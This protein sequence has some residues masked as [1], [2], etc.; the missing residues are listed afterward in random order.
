MN[1]VRQHYQNENDRV[2]YN[3]FTAKELASIIFKNIEKACQPEIATE[4][5]DSLQ[6]LLRT[7][8]PKHA[9]AYAARLNQLLSMLKEKLSP[10][11]EH[12]PTLGVVNNHSKIDASKFPGLSLNTNFEQNRILINDSLL[13]LDVLSQKKQ[14]D[15]YHWYSYLRFWS[16][17]QWPG[18]NMIFLV[19][20]LVIGVFVP[21]IGLTML[22]FTCIYTAISVVDFSVQSESYWQWQD[23]PGLST[24][25]QPIDAQ[26]GLESEEESAALLTDNKKPTNAS[27][28]FNRLNA[29]CYYGDIVAIGI[30]VIGIISLVFP[31][32]GISMLALTILAGVAIFIAA[33][34]FGAFLKHRKLEGIELQTIENKLHNDPEK[35][36]SSEL[37]DLF[38]DCTINNTSATEVS[39][40]V[41]SQPTTPEEHSQK[42]QPQRTIISWISN[43][44]KPTMAM[45]VESIKNPSKIKPSNSDE[46]SDADSESHQL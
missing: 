5:A 45:D 23:Y 1:Q 14:D 10:Q 25:M 38:H 15:L 8:K 11:L 2:N 6:G 4:V 22:I 26:P 16:D 3:D 34:Q 31:P 37:N 33:V 20:P 18:M 24:G 46:D 35:I 32:I 13:A 36:L 40:S 12:D 42:K 17:K 41:S 7:K 9:T 27:N 44:M 30:C 28:H 19:V 43:M 29:F 21:P 39:L